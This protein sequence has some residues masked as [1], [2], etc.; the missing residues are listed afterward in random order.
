MMEKDFL[1]LRDMYYLTAREK[2][3]PVL[4]LSRVTSIGCYCPTFTFSWQNTRD[5]RRWQ[6]LKTA[7]KIKRDLI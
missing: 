2:V 6:T 5:F 3:V 4:L 1:H 7:I